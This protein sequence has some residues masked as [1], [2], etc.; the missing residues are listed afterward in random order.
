MISR[1]V[2]DAAVATAH[3]HVTRETARQLGE[4][5]GGAGMQAQLIA[6][7]RTGLDHG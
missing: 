5:G 4:L 3:E 6:D 1:G 7:G 2:L